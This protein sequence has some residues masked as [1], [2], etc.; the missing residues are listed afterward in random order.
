[1]PGWYLIVVG[2]RLRPDYYNRFGAM[3]L[4]E[5][6]TNAE[7]SVFLGNLRDQAELSGVLDAFYEL[8]IPLYTVQHL[9]EFD[10]LS[11]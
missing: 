2:G 7:I 10:E 8:H 1:M 5:T 6:P 4:M 9:G 3:Q 11:D